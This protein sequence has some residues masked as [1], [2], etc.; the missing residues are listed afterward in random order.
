MSWSKGDCRG[1][2][3]AASSRE[4]SWQLPVWPAFQPLQLFGV[5]LVFHLDGEPLRA[6]VVPVLFSRP[7]T[8]A[9]QHG[10]KGRSTPRSVRPVAGSPH[11]GP[12]PSRVLCRCAGPHLGGVPLTRLC[13][14]RTRGCPTPW[15]PFQGTPAGWRGV[16]ESLCRKRRPRQ[17]SPPGGVSG[18]LRQPTSP[19]CARR[20]PGP[21]SPSHT[22]QGRPWPQRAAGH[23]ASDGGGP[24]RPRA[25][26]AASC[27]CSL[28][29]PRVQGPWTRRGAARL[30]A[31]ICCGGVPR[32][33]ACCAAAAGQGPGSRSV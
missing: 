28:R 10:C 6:G 24:P 27:G 7:P 13:L 16:S 8:T 4:A 5:L 12:A 3:P 32:R 20:L 25:G 9:S 26:G 15:S 18:N 21:P 2:P 14:R 31:L 22:W 17:V 11:G 30:L 19:I 29:C 1:P 33:P 23:R